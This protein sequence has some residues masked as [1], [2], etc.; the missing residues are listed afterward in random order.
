[1][2]SHAPLFFLPVVSMTH[3]YCCEQGVVQRAYNA[4]AVRMVCEGGGERRIVPINETPEGELCIE[5]RIRLYPDGAMS[6]LLMQL[7]KVLA[8]DVHLELWS[9]GMNVGSLV[10][11]LA[12][13]SFHL[14]HGS[15]GNMAYSPECGVLELHAV[16]HEL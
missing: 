14:L 6:N 15:H 12:N 4:F 8:C 5:M 16:A 10:K 7:I 1:M 9:R 13:V 11:M 2:R 3:R